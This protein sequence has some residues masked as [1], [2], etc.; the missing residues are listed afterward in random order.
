MMRE[1]TRR[2]TLRRRTSHRKT[3]TSNSQLDAIQRGQKVLDAR[4]QDMQVTVATYHLQRSTD[5]S[6]F[7]F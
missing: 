2:A 5:V 6:V 4:L 7:K 3:R 1:M